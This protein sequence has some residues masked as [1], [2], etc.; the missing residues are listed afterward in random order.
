LYNNNL[1]KST[2]NDLA[3]QQEYSTKKADLEAQ[4][5]QIKRELAEK[6]RELVD[7][8]DEALIFRI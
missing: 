2:Q 6:E 7:S 1:H 4:I 8:L 3:E 5:E